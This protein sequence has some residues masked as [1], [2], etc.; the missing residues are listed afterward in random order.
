MVLIL[1]TKYNKSVLGCLQY[2][3]NETL[4]KITG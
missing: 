2:N 3:H 1:P 4:N